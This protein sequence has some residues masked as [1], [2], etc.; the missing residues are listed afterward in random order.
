MHHLGVVEA[1]HC[2][3]I[4]FFVE[5]EYNTAIGGVNLIWPVE[6]TLSAALDVDHDG[7]DAHEEKPKN[8]NGLENRRALVVKNEKPGYPTLLETSR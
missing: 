3:Y 1:C 5:P 6:P 8:T 7:S 4:P 2:R